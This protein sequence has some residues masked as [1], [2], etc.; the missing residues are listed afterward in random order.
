MFQMT[1]EKMAIAKEYYAQAI[2]DIEKA[3]EV[4]EAVRQ[5]NDQALERAGKTAADKELQIAA[6]VADI[7]A[8]YKI[9]VTFEKNRTS[10]GPNLLGIQVWESGK[11][12]NGGGDELAFFC[13]DVKSD[14]GC[15]GVITSDFIKGGVAYCQTC[16]KGVVADRLTNMILGKVS[17]QALAEQLA[18]MFRQ[19]NSN[20][21]ILIKYHKTDPRYV[22]MERAKGPD[23]AKRLKGMHIYPLK[24]ILKDTS[25]GADL[26][27]RFKA[28]V[29]S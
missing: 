6:T 4:T 13:K 29:C 1:S 7:R 20:A 23:V 12:F 5:H 18:K 26:V 19:L 27:K 10:Q 11:R 8:K 15:F 17:S 3:K 14:E 22:S 25:A 21:D 2:K 9:E 28:F 16:N 24:N